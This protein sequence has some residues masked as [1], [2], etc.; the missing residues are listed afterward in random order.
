[1]NKLL[2]LIFLFPIIVWGQSERPNIV[3]ITCEDIS[4][5]LS[6]Y[7]DST[8][9]TPVLDKLASESQV[10]QNAFVAV[11]VCGPSMSSMMTGV[12]PISMGTHNM[13]TGRDVIGWGDRKYDREHYAFD[14]NGDNIPHYSAVIP[15]DIRVFTQLLREAGYFTANNCKTDYQ[16]AA[17]VTAWDENSGQAHWKHRK[18]G[19]PFFYMHTIYETHESRMWQNDHKPLTVDP[20]KV[21]LPS[22]YPDTDTVRHDVARNYS[23]IEI[24]DQLVGEKLK[25]LEEAGL[26]DNTI[27]FFFSDHG[28]PLPRGKRASLLSGLRTPLIVRMPGNLKQ[29]DIDD[30]VSFVDLAPTVLSLAGVEIPKYIQGQAFLGDKKA[31]KKRTFTF[32]SADRFDEHSDRIRTVVSDEFI[33]VRNYH[34]EL[35]SYKDNRYRKKIPMMREMYKLNEEGKLEGAE[36]RWFRKEKREEELYVRAKDP[37]NVVNVIDDP[38]YVD[39][40]N[41]M[42]KAMDQWLNKVGDLGAIPETEMVVGMWPNF[43]QPQTNTP[44][45]K[46]KG[47]QVKLSCDTKGAEIAYIVSNKELT[48][49][50]NAGW[51]VYTAPL[52]LKQGEYLYTMSVR[53]GYKAS[54]VISYKL[55]LNN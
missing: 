10:Y 38:K 37:D 54:E 50:L 17:P 9:K 45:L 8:A 5:N 48:P 15:E 33:Y 3:W 39:T 35:P 16:F 1:M 6:M 13:R 42:R 12:Y 44:Y 24:M 47:N 41:E 32:A 27:V 11:P 26:M 30:L 28:G 43:I 29:E 22:Y 46:A 21:P 51:N 31:K 49:D 34:P 14:I 20:S 4:P 18:E 52:N 25:E 53:I 23:N 36:K 40:I 19:Q 7:G 55:P 2:L